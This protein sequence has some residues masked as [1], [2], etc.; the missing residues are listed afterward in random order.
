M[1]AMASPGYGPLDRI[2]RVAVPTPSPGRGKVRVR[3]HT[4]ALNPAD[5]KVVL[6]SMKFLHARNRPLI[7][8]Y[9]F[10]GVVDAI[11]DGVTNYAP[12]QE[13]F[14][15]LPYSPM[16]R[17]GAFAEFVV[18]RTNEISPKPLS[19]PHSL[20]SAAATP[21][22]SA[23]QALRDLGRIR[24]GHRVLITG[25]SGGVGLLAVSVACKLGASVTVIGSGR[26]LELARME[27]AVAVID[28]KS[29]DVL[30]RLS[31]TYDVIF[32]AAAAYRWRTFKRFLAP[33]GSYVTTL[34]SMAFLSDKL[35]SLFTSTRAGFLNVKAR[36]ADLEQLAAWLAGGMHV[37]V[38]STIPVRD[39]ATGLARLKNGGVVGRVVVNVKDNF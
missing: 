29:G 13:V 9:D 37:T 18:A 4:S 20:A 10:S 15:F 30:N 1:F 35:A 32:D 26:G 22:V 3:V 21:G 27:G 36:P 33:G 19:A 5:F 17:Q 11:G 25:A 39:V 28:R 12:G 7:V 16:N 14:G 34:P 6:G 24:S 2:V 8:G 31:G 38:D 23:L